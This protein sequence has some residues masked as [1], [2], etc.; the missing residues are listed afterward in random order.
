M[1]RKPVEIVLADDWNEVVAVWFPVSRTVYIEGKHCSDPQEVE[2]RFDRIK[3]YKQAKALVVE[4]GG[5]RPRA[6]V[7][8]TNDMLL[9]K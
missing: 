6:I 7:R 9:F 4:V 5:F 8:V 2:A 3:T 1:T